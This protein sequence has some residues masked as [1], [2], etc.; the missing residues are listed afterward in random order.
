[1]RRSKAKR[2]IDKLLSNLEAKVKEEK[3]L[4]WAVPVVRVLTFNDEDG[5]FS[6]ERLADFLSNV[7]SLAYSAIDD[8]YQKGGSLA[9]KQD[10]EILLSL[11]MN[12][13]WEVVNTWN[14]SEEKPEEEKQGNMRTEEE[15]EQ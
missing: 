10:L 14:A 2:E 5:N 9:K 11:T 3:M 15:D 1:M 12:T 4:V 13:I 6:E 8:I 7:K